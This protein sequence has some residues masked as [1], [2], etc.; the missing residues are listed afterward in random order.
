MTVAPH[1]RPIAHELPAVY[2]R[3]TESFSQIEGYLGLVDELSRAYTSRLD[4]IASWLSPDA[5]E[6]WPPG[7]PIGAT[8]DA[9]LDRYASL[10]D[11]IARW[12]G[13]VFPGSWNDANQGLAHKREFLL[14][15][16]RIWRRRMTPRGLLDWICLAFEI[17][18]PDRPIL[19]EHFKFGRPETAGG[20][21]GEEPFLRATLLV[22]SSDQFTDYA[23]RR[24]LLEFVDVSAAAHVY[25]RVCWV[26]QGFTL[27]PPDP[28]NESDR[29]DFEKEIRELLC[30]H[31]SDIPYESGAGAPACAKEGSPKDRLG[32]ARLPTKP[33]DVSFPECDEEN[34]S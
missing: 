17:A 18:E 28:T 22:P 33:H 25:V 21:L 30:S 32:I 24:E 31:V 29:A 19:L 13:Y 1:Y 26:E 7:I 2:R 6:M 4:D 3:D 5:T 11:E 8:H 14:R 16:A 10:F 27:A 15:A 12:F 20:E 34:T 9:V 23:R